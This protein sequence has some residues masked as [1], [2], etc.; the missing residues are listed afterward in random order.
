MLPLLSGRQVRTS[1]TSDAGSPRVRK[2]CDFWAPALRSWIDVSTQID[3]APHHLPKCS[4]VGSLTL[5]SCMPPVA[6]HGDRAEMTA[7]LTKG[8]D[9]IS[10]TGDVIAFEVT[11]VNIGTGCLYQLSLTDALG[12]IMACQPVYTGMPLPLHSPDL[13]RT[14]LNVCTSM[15]TALCP[16]KSTRT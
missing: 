14:L 10:S 5:D 4:L 11:V 1:I 2:C 13:R 7:A 16:S 8:V 12:T 6:D 3:A 9:G 15:H